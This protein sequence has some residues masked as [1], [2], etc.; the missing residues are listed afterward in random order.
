MNRTETARNTLSL[1][2]VAELRDL[3]REAGI[4]GRSKLRKAELVAA[5]LPAHLAEMAEVATRR[6]PAEAD[7]ETALAARQWDGSLGARM[8]DGSLVAAAIRAKE[9]YLEVVGRL[10]AEN[11]GPAVSIAWEDYLD[12]CF[13]AETCT[14]VTCWDRATD[15][16]RCGR[17]SHGPALG[18]D[19][20]ASEPVSRETVPAEV[21]E[22]RSPADVWARVTAAKDAAMAELKRALPQSG[23][24][25]CACRDCFDITIGGS[26]CHH[27]EEAGCSDDGEQ[28]CYRDDAYEG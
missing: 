1:M 16:G 25:D 2:T 12:A 24:T 21:A 7:R 6:A 11:G 13:A 28:E 22:V 5:L 26:V 17:H 23:Y 8:T 3:A 15:D 9:T 18:N 27:C 20:V 10:G 4:A 19:V 14:F